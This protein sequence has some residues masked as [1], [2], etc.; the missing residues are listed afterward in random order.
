[1]RAHI[2][3]ACTRPGNLPAVAE[4]IMAATCDP[5][6]VTW[7]IR[8]DP[9]QQHVGGQRLKNE[10]LDQIEDGWVCFLDDDTTMHPDFLRRM[11]EAVKDAGAVVV[12]QQRQNGMVLVAADGH[13]QVG[14]V[15]IGQAFIARSLIGTHRIP[16]H[17]EG[18]GMF[19]QAVLAGHYFVTYLPDVLSEHN[20]LEP[21]AV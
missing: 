6:D 9:E 17:Y 7:H 21:V 12:S 18:D 4:S 5:W 1:M 16:E 3:T 2:I 14:S 10:M 20:A 8:F 19:L 11:A 13:L 15:D